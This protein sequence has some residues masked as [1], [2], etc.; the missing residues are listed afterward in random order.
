MPGLEKR[1]NLPQPFLGEGRETGQKTTNLAIPISFI[2][3][4][5]FQRLYICQ[6]Q[7]LYF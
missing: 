1:S 6:T 3:K 5:T 4:E 7:S 2:K